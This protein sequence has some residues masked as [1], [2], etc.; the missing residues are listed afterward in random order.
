MIQ[1]VCSVRTPFRRAGEASSVN[2]AS[3]LAVGLFCCR[4]SKPR[5]R[6]SFR[7]T[8]MHLDI[9]SAD[10]LATPQE[11]Y[12]KSQVSGEWLHSLGVG[13]G[14]RVR[15]L[16]LQEARIQG[17]NKVSITLVTVVLVMNIGFQIISLSVYFKWQKERK[18][19]LMG[20]RN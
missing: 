12:F 2:L 19:C 3:R 9:A 5:N 1:S 6:P 20:A 7:Q 16:K 18:C 15:L 10:V 11:T 8:L 17:A 4:Q 13:V 14:K